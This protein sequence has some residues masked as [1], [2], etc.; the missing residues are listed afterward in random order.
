MSITVSYGH[1]ARGLE[2]VSVAIPMASRCC[3][4]CLKALQYSTPRTQTLPQHRLTPCES[5]LEA[6]FGVPH[7]FVY[8]QIKVFTAVALCY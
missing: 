8:I 2:I 3:F 1:L 6:N 4:M 7:R 5:Q